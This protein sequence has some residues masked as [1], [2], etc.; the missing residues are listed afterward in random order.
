[1]ADVRGFTCAVCGGRL[2][3]ENSVCVTCG[4]DQG[5][6]M[7]RM[8]LVPVPTDGSAAVCANLGLAAC[9]WLVPA[10]G[11]LC[12]SC[13]L[14]R[15]RPA[16]EDLVGLGRFATVEGAK[17]R[18]V[19]QLLDLRLPVVPRTD[20]AD[21]LAFDLLSS[22]DEPVT[23]GH[24]DGIVT[25]DLAEGDD[26]QREAVRLEMGEAYRTVLGH[27]RHEV[28]HYY[29]QV[30]VEARSPGSGWNRDPGS[31]R[32]WESGADSVDRFRALF[33]DERED[34]A[35]ALRRHYG[36]PP[37]PSW[38]DRH[39]SAY[40]TA[41]PWEDWAE[42]FAHYL[43]ITDTLQTAAAQG[44]TAGGPDPVD[45]PDRLETAQQLVDRWLPLAYALNEV[46]RSMGVGDLYP[47][48]L[49][50]VVIEKLA[51]VHGLVVGPP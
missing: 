24:A 2:G 38:N 6:S 21:G 9:Q 10:P 8:A 42:T 15:T 3:F 30:L 48:V 35:A 46:S 28:G 13:R 19:Y 47:F 4:T 51:F 33:G 34:Y 11:M 1:V 17:R 18:L 26:A 45:S 25:L 37:D 20:D 29:W 12:L 16:D 39:V 23:T 5:F 31:G 7:T 43:H 44:L 36:G 32:P 50:E 14:T 40:A 22:R 41:H 27:L 49:S